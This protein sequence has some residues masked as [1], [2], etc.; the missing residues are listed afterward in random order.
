[1]AVQI[2]KNESAHV[3]AVCGPTGAD[4][5][6]SIGADAIVDY[7]REDFAAR[8]ERYDIIMDNV[9]NTPFAKVK[10]MLGANGRFIMVVGNLPQMI[11]AAFN[12]R[13]VGGVAM[14]T[15]DAYRSIIKRAAV[16]ELRPLIERTFSLDD[17]VEAHRHVDTG[18]KKGSVV[19][20]PSEA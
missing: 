15:V 13:I 9:G 4:I 6:R 18:R 17:I 12:K 19:I 14:G 20:V 5:V 3:T 8:S 2:A 16:G 1:M 7:S 11:A 10:H